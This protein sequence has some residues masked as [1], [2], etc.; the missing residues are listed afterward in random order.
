MWYIV[1][2]ESASYKH[3]RLHP[4]QLLDIHVAFVILKGVGKENVAKKWIDAPS[5]RYFR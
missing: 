5:S 1:C 4:L 2:Y 3:V